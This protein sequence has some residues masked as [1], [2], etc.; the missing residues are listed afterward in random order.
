MPK[1]FTGGFANADLN[2]VRGSRRLGKVAAA[3]S[4]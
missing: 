2:D 3:G 4:C 1:D